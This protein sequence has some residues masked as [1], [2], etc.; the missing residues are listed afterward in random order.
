MAMSEYELTEG[1]LGDLLHQTDEG[2]K[3]ALTYDSSYTDRDVTKFG[4]VTD[5]D[6]SPWVRIDHTAAEVSYYVYTSGMADRDKG[7]VVKDD[8]EH[9]QK[10]GT[11]ESFERNPDGMV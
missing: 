6:T 3:V 7:D 10:V 2:A 5:T 9:K 11:F 1:T 8:G 4:R